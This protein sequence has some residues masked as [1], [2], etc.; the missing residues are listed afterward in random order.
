MAKNKGAEAPKVSPEDTKFES[1][2]EQMAS[3][4]GSEEKALEEMFDETIEEAAH[5]LGLE[6]QQAEKYR[7]TMQAYKDKIIAKALETKKPGATLIAEL[8][9]RDVTGESIP[10]SKL[11]SYEHVVESSVDEIGDEL[12]LDGL[13]MNYWKKAMLERKNALA[14]QAAPEADAT[15]KLLDMMRDKD[16]VDHAKA[17][18]NLIEQYQSSTPEEQAQMLSNSEKFFNDGKAE[19]NAIAV[20]EAFLEDVRQGGIGKTKTSGV[21]TESENEDDPKTNRLPKTGE[22]VS[23]KKEPT[24]KTGGIMGFLRGLF[25]GK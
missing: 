6:G 17:Y 7:E 21:L 13:E 2:L 10:E 19:A 14:R 24:K 8:H 16:F 23:A 11:R 18:G 12:G 25:G 22:V 3:E 4:I 15:A 20:H 5:E 9:G 1:E